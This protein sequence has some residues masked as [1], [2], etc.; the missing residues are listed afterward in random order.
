MTADNFPAHVLHFTE[1]FVLPV[2]PA[3]SLLERE[4]TTI[5]KK[6]SNPT[7]EIEVLNWTKFDLIKL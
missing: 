1:I 4:N 5:P 2:L 7:H 3:P 6:I